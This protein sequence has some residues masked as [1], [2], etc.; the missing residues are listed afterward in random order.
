MVPYI[1]AST[2]FSFGGLF[3]RVG[4]FMID[5]SREIYYILGLASIMQ[6][7][8]LCFIVDTWQYWDP[9]NTILFRISNFSGILEV[10]TQLPFKWNR[11]F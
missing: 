9:T 1:N 8:E 6:Y 5:I 7:M 10:N 11:Y 2:W 3:L 4:Y